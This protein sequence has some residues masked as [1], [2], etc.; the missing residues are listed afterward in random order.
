LSRHP[1]YVMKTV[2]IIMY[3][4]LEMYVVCASLLRFKATYTHTHIHMICSP[5]PTRYYRPVW[6]P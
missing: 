4:S 5:L 1:G 2:Y 6:Y 3:L